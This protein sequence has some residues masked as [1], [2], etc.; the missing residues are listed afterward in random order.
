MEFDIGH[1]YGNNTP[2]LEHKPA[3]HFT[4]KSVRSNHQVVSAVEA[5]FDRVMNAA[6]TSR[7]KLFDESP[8]VISKWRGVWPRLF[9]G[10]WI[11]W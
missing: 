7:A 8:P 2:R 11:I 5:W 10:E 1:R 6:E 9:A 4:V 3:A